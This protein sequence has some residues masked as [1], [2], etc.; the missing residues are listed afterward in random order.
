[1]DGEGLFQHASTFQMISPRQAQPDP[2]SAVLAR[3]P[4]RRVRLRG[5][6]PVALRPTLSDGL[7]FS[8]I[9]SSKIVHGAYFSKGNASIAASGQFP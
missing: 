6:R 1:M 5:F 2:K 3:Q 4:R 9:I 7:P 8:S